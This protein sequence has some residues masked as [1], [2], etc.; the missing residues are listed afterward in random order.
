MQVIFFLNNKKPPHRS[1]E[2]KVEE[3]GG[4]KV[5]GAG[6][7]QAGAVGGGDR[8]G[9]VRG[10]HGVPDTFPTSQYPFLFLNHL[11]NCHPK[12][13]WGDNSTAGILWGDNCTGGNL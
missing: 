12:L 6:Q 11:Y 10:M 2:G 3:G 9:A 5:Q 13:E 8:Q 4:L 1:H 7:Q